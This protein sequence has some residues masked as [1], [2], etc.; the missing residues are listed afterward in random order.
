MKK[1]IVASTNPAKINAALD[2]FLRMFP[3]EEF[4][5]Q[6]VSVASGV[7]DQP[8]GDQETFRGA[9]NRAT[10]A[11]VA[12]PD[13]DFYVGLEGGI[14][15]KG[16]EMEAFAWMVVISR[17]GK[18]GKGRTGVFFLPPQV[19]ALINEGKELG[20]ADDIVFKKQNSKQANG[21][22]GILTNDVITRTAFYSE[23]MVFA[24]IPFKNSE[25]Y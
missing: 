9:I 10:N 13:A 11:K 22:V 2:G 21:A 4:N 19:A 18:V 1:I 17:D 16:D 12:V 20:E 14:E 7:S 8:M 15:A 23:A 5:V 3:E 24:L 6:G 25:L